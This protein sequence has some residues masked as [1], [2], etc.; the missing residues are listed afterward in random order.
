MG[1]RSRSRLKYQRV[2]PFGLVQYGNCALIN[3]ERAAIHAWE[4]P[5][6]LSEFVKL[7]PGTP[8]NTSD[9][10]E[11]QQTK[12]WAS[13]Q[14]LHRAAERN[15]VHAHSMGTALCGCALTFHFGFPQDFIVGSSSQSSRVLLAG[16]QM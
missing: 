3:I 14:L 9:S 1:V 16:T 13:V 15:V 4:C 6:P 2:I 8:T 12:L 10:F 11:E 7:W 5:V